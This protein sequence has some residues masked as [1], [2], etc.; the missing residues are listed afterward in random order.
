MSH[1]TSTSQK[2]LRDLHIGHVL[3][4]NFGKERLESGTQTYWERKKGSA[5]TL[6]KITI[7]R[8]RKTEKVPIIQSALNASKST[9]SLTYN[10]VQTWD[11]Q[12]RQH[13]LCMNSILPAIAP[14][15]GQDL[16]RISGQVCH[17]QRWQAPLNDP[18]HTLQ[19]KTAT[20]ALEHNAKKEERL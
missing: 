10:S 11:C 14:P 12:G 2:D 20:V 19:L 7:S 15:E 6:K 13:R 5:L 1:V 3:S 18:D 4:R 16:D 17:S 8:N 9:F